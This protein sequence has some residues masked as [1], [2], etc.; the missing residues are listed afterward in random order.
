[1]DIKRQIS[2]SDF[3]DK[4]NLESQIKFVLSYA[5]L[6]PS[7]HNSQPWLFKI[8]ASECQIY[9]DPKLVL[10]EADP[11]TRDLHISIGC[12]VENL[13]LAATYFNI[14]DSINYGPFEYKE[15]LATVNFKKYTG[16]RNDKYKRILN[17]ITK[18]IDARGLFSSEPVPIDLI[19]RISSVVQEYLVYNI[20]IH[21]ITEKNKIIKLSLL[22][23]DGLKAAYRSPI[24]R[25]EMSRWMRHSLTK[26]KDGIPGY[27]L[28]MP[29]LLSFMLPTLVRWFNLGGLLSKLNYKSLSSAPLVTV[30]TA[31]KD[32]PNTWLNIGRLVERLFLEFNSFGWQTSI[33]VAAVEMGNFY[34]EIQKIIGTNQIPQFL[35]VV[36]KVDLLHK[37]T[38]R[39]ELTKKIIS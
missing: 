15:H 36:G 27:A 30:I 18:R 26:S 35:F 11:K 9:Y 14:F 33:F 29:F 6:A 38:P 7:T 22:T 5:I 20:N 12:T 39:H 25:R 10:P 1:M 28:R 34:S 8:K 32:H 37:A 24:F 4:A 3:P 17:T 31:D 23:A 2:I 13:I 16:V 19:N 21:W